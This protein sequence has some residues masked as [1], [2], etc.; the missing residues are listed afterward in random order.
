MWLEQTCA[1]AGRK[2]FPFHALQA[3]TSPPP[4]E[5]NFLGPRTSRP[6]K[7]LLGTWFSLGFVPGVRSVTPPSP[8]KSKQDG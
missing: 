1:L 2:D 3:E 5:G 6:W 4:L 7:N 8:S